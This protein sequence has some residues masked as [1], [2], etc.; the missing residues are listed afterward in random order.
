MSQPQTPPLAVRTRE[1]AR[2]LNIS[3]RTLFAL[4][5]PR[6]PIP[7]VK[8]GGK[9]GSVLY[10]VNDLDAWLQRAAQRPAGG[11]DAAGAD[12]AAVAD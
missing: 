1:A 7:C 3:A 12:A 4:T 8:L 10:R 2:M 11:S 6:G 9:R 5:A